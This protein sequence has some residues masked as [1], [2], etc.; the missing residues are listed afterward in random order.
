MLILDHYYFIYK[1]FFYRSQFQIVICIENFQEHSRTIYIHFLHSAFYNTTANVNPSTNCWIICLVIFIYTQDL[2]EI[3]MH[4]WL[5]PR[6]FFL[7]TKN[8]AKKV[9]HSCFQHTMDAFYEDVVFR[10]SDF[11]TKLRH[12]YQS[13]SFDLFRRCVS[14]RKSDTLIRLCLVFESFEIL[15]GVCDVVVSCL[16]LI[17]Y[18]MCGKRV[19]YPR[20]EMKFVSLEPSSFNGHFDSFDVKMFKFRMIVDKIQFRDVLG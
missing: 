10:V 4:V 11:R 5:R 7:C 8:R 6:G 12:L 14:L 17:I 3:F 2:L 18:L 16:V 20:W 15:I 13:S 9:L 19:H 1:S